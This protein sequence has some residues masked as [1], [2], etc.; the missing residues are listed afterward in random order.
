MSNQQWTRA[1]DSLI[2]ERAEGLKVFRTASE[3]WVE[4]ATGHR[5]LDHYLTDLAA[6]ARAQESWRLQEPEKR[7]YGVHV[8]RNGAECF[9][10]WD[11]EPGPSEDRENE[12]AARA[13]ATWRACGG[14]E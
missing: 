9:M 7:W 1:H 5:P 3:W 14:G 13:W 6:I 10:F 11:A 4:T 2:A 12:R 8:H